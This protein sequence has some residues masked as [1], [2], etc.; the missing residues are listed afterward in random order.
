MKRSG[1][2]CE[3]IGRQGVDA[4]DENLAEGVDEL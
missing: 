1:R 4:C 2:S 3:Q